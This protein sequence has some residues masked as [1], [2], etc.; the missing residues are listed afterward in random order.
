MLKEIEDK[1]LQVLS[2]SSGNIL[3]DEAAINVLSSSKALANDI[4]EKQLIAEETE[5]K[6]DAARL[7]YTPI[8]VHSTIL[9]FSIADLANIEPMYQYSL[10]WFVNLFVASIENS[11]KSDILE[12]R[13]A[14]L[15]NHFT[16]SLYSNICR[17]LFE[18]DKLLFSFLLCVNLLKYEK[19]IDEDEWRFLLT[20]GVAL[21]NT[22]SNPT[23][24]LPQKSWDELVRLDELTRFKDI[25]KN[26][27]AQKDGWKIVYDSLEPHREKFPDQ[28]QTVLQDFQRM[29]VIRCIRPDKVI[30]AVQD[31]V[32]DHLGS[33]YIEP[34]PFD[35]AKSYQDSTCVT[36]V[37]FVLSPGSDPMSSLSKFADD[38]VSLKISFLIFNKISFSGFWWSKN[39]V[40]FTGSRTV[41]VQTIFSNIVDVLVHRFRGPYAVQNIQKGI[42][43]GNWVVLQN[44]HLA[45][46]WMPQLEKICEVRRL[47]SIFRLIFNCF[48]LL[49]EFNPDTIHP[50]FRLWLTSYPSDKF[51]VAILQNGV[52]LTNEAPKGLR[53]NLL[54]SYLSDPIKDPEFFGNAKNPVRRFFIRFQLFHQ[55]FFVCLA[56]MEEITFR[57]L[58]FSRSR[59]RTS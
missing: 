30:P 28:W 37:I 42:K 48:G 52:K 24:W 2:A 26:F 20:G 39:A 46:S 44:C 33:K 58:L 23:A 1:I 38:M 4:S 25:R 9:F 50:D 21:S 59:S 32:R 43:E 27:L 22:F 10:T 7:G 16:Y 5:K 47:C 19:K 36:P 12:T 49:Q 35:L 53:F 13:L 55:E 54:R 15:R 56:S 18:K 57:S 11:E 17:S 29:C 3:E 41:S 51:P 14:S 40:T 6:I 45:P 8:A 34:P 31:F